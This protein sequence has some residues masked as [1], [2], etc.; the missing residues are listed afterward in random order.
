MLVSDYAE[1]INSTSIVNDTG[2]SHEEAEI[3]SSALTVNDTD[4]SHGESEIRGNFFFY[5]FSLKKISCIMPY[6]SPFN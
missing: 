1:T 6:L 5:V 4:S 3:M 2:S